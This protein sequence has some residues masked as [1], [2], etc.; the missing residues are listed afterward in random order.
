MIK[1][2]L[3]SEYFFKTFWVKISGNNFCELDS[4]NIRLAFKSV[5]GDPKTV[6]LFD[7]SLDS[8]LWFYCSH[9]FSFQMFSH[10]IRF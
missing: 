8:G 7:K 1:M 2:Q 9:V 3:S 5:P 6:L 4:T 10:K